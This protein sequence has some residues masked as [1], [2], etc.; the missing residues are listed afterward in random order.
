MD[1]SRDFKELLELLNAH[2][3][4]YVVAGAHALAFHG[5]P[6]YTGDI[7]I[8]ILPQ[9]DNAARMIAVLREFG[10]GSLGL[11]AADLQE[12][13]QIVQL[14]FPP[15]RIDL[16]TSL[17]GVSWEEIEAGKVAGELGGVGVHFVGKR[18]YVKNKRAV[19]RLKDLAD[20][21]AIEGQ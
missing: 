19:G 3:V 4:R 20:I 6:R 17:T 5:A 2:D 13:G 18:E 9:P 10:F 1:I 7:D 14:G 8:C 12:D 11:T 16:M 15:T 21:E